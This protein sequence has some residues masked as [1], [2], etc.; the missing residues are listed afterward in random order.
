MHVE[1]ELWLQSIQVWLIH[2]VRYNASWINSVLGWTLSLEI[3]NV[4][5]SNLVVLDKLW[6]EPIVIDHL[7]LYHHQL[8]LESVHIQ[9]SMEESKQFEIYVQ[10]YRLWRYVVVVAFKT[11]IHLFK[12][13]VFKNVMVLPI[14][15]CQI[16]LLLHLKVAQLIAKATISVS[17]WYM[18]KA[19][20]SVWPTALAAPEPQILLLQAL[21]LLTDPLTLCLH[22]LRW[23][24]VL[25]W[26]FILE[27]QALET[28]VQD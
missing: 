12:L 24:H 16:Q 19:Q 21:T 5:F 6:L 3:I 22:H 10:L 20:N 15:Y 9:K 25:I 13:Q 1:V 8:L 4:N 17:S 23:T 11:Q 27:I 28:P 18:S 2:I 7:T 14:F 26:W